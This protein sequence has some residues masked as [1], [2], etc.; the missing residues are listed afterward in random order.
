MFG[1]KVRMRNLLRNSIFFLILLLPVLVQAQKDGVNTNHE[2]K[3]QVEKKASLGTYQ[4]VVSA[5]DS[6]FVFTNDILVQ[7]EKLRKEKE[8]V[9]FSV[10]TSVMVRILSK[11]EIMEPG[12]KPVDEIVYKEQ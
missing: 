1:Y 7:I 11:S 4:F 9:L 2:E 10:T 12:F 3:I 5:A 8:E 6:Q